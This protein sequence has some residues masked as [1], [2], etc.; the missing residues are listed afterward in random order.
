[1][2]LPAVCCMESAVL[3]ACVS[4]TVV[5]RRTTQ[6]HSVVRPLWVITHTHCIVAGHLKMADSRSRSTCAVSRLSTTTSGLCLT[7]PTCCSATTSTSTLST[8]L[9]SK[10]S[11]TCT[12]IS[13]RDDRIV[14]LLTA[15]KSSLAI[16]D[17]VIEL[18]DS[19]YS[20]LDNHEFVIG[21]Y[22]DLQ[23]AFDTVDHKILY[24]SFSSYG[25]IYLK[26]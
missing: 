10:S 23:K 18:C 26:I 13:S 22:F 24:M 7:T 5:A 25:T 17:N 8:A 21:M 4:R 20:H 6:S 15:D 11:N 12:R 1:M 19:L 3:A 16:D 14:A 9:P 2:S